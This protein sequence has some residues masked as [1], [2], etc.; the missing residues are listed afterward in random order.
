MRHLA[1]VDRFIALSAGKTIPEIFS[2]AG[3]VALHYEF[4][5]PESLARRRWL[6]RASVFGAGQF[7]SVT[8]QLLDAK[9]DQMSRDIH[10][11]YGEA[12]GRYGFPHGHPLGVDRQGA[13]F[14]EAVA[15]KLDQR[16]AICVP[17]T[18]TREQLE[19]FHTPGYVEDVLR[20]ENDDREYLDNGDTPIFPGVYEAGATVVGSALDGL[21]HIMRA[22][23]RV[24]FQPIGGLHHA[25][26]NG[27]AGFCVFNDLGVVI[28]TL[29]AEY[30]IQ[31]I[32]YVDIDV[33]HGDGVFYA[34]E[35]D[36]ELIFADIHEDGRSL[37]P[38]TGSASETGKGS[39]KG[40]KLN[41]PLP[42]G[43]G[44]A[45]FLETWPRVVAHVRKF[46]PQ[47]IVF[48]CGADGLEGD[49]LAHL[50]YSM[51]VHAHATRSLRHLADEMAA[52]RLMAFGGGGY[53]RDNLAKA[54]CAV[55]RELSAA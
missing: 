39:A 18:A 29:R 12:L 9:Q 27:A 54:W 42:P 53:Q 4:G 30:G 15:Q 6:C 16:V 37:Y 17:Q 46:H 47:F 20:A 35:E 1:T 31:R 32:A 52:G 45:E 55:L 25:R 28:E 43:A 2:C 41:I 24:T 48:Q 26:R 7:G 11:Y 50:R 40:T 51:H 19:R 36:P 34:Y 10:L 38:G 44:D 33:H 23:C 14:K 49:P 13:F 8:A 3:V 5:S 21:A 22:Q